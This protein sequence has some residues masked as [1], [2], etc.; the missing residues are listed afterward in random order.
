MIDDD[1][2]SFSC[3]LKPTSMKADPKALEVSGLSL[4]GLD[5]TGLPPGEAMRRFDHWA[6]GLARE[7]QTLVFVGFNA[8]FDW[9]FIN[10]YFW[11]YL[12][13]NPFGFAALD[14]KSFYMGALNC[15]WADTRSSRIARDLKPSRQGD[16]DALHDAKYQ[17]ELFRLMRARPHTLGRDGS[18]PADLP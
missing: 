13:R 14:I 16:H 8:S 6:T 12:G 18:E 10:Y 9:S 7:G 17:A 1:T 5:E 15:G 11:K 4:E 3:S 2:Q